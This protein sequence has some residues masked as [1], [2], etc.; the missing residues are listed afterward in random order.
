MRQTC[1]LPQQHGC[2]RRRS[3]SWGNTS[4]A[5]AWARALHFSK[6]LA[7]LVLKNQYL[8]VGWFVYFLI[9]MFPFVG[10]TMGLS[11]RNARCQCPLHLMGHQCA[12]VGTAGPL[13][14]AQAW[15]GRLQR[16]LLVNSVTEFTAG[17]WGLEVS[18]ASVSRGTFTRCCHLVLV[19]AG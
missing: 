12:C 8:T 10:F 6:S 17:I 11:D 1:K 13:L 19:V 14:A 5:A 15:D 4:P 7:S 3:S 9:S 16:R 18:A 2:C